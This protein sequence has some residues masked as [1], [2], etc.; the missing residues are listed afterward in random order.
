[1]AHYDDLAVLCNVSHK[2]QSFCVNS[3]YNDHN[4]L[5]L[6]SPRLKDVNCME[7]MTSRLQLQRDIY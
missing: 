4:K 5:A 1:M 6:S 2:M 7:N 3:P